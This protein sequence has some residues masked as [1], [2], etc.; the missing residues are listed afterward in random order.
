MFCNYAYRI[1]E[2]RNKSTVK[3]KTRYFRAF[4]ILR[5]LEA[6]LPSLFAKQL[7]HDFVDQRAV[8][9]AFDLRHENGHDFANFFFVF[10]P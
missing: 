1:H 3:G 8:G 10:Y 9:F 5:N 2:Y 4:F 6:Q 7:P